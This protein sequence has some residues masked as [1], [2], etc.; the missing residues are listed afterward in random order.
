MKN[1]I[2]LPSLFFTFY[3]TYIQEICA[4]ACLQ[5]FWFRAV[6]VCGY[7]GLWSFWFAAGDGGGR[8]SS[9]MSLAVASVGGYSHGH[10]AS[11]I[12]VGS[13]GDDTNPR[14]PEPL[15]VRGGWLWLIWVV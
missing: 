12:G 13:F 3:V 11:P 5:P 7:F 15:V 1:A 2:G 10:P 8:P 14:A 6:P 9:V 4:H